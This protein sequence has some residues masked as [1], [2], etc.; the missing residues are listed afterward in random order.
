MQLGE[1]Q[2]AQFLN[3]GHLPGWGGL[4]GRGPDKAEADRSRARGRYPTNTRE[5]A[6]S[7]SEAS[8]SS[9]YF[10]RTKNQPSILYKNVAVGVTMTLG[11]AR[12]PQKLPKN[13]RARPKPP[14]LWKKNYKEY[15]GRS[16]LPSSPSPM[17]K[18]G[19]GTENGGLSWWPRW[20][21]RK[22]AVFK[23]QGI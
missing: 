3:F 19:G 14:K 20:E 7:K 22:V 5:R 16:C 21:A 1:S 17:Q 4:Q 23:K 8:F 11:P 9:V 10:K 18:L 2:E 12:P 13:T 6:S 15:R